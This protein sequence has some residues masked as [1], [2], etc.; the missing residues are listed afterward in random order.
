MVK[1]RD[2]ATRRRVDERKGMKEKS[3][4]RGKEGRRGERRVA[5]ALGRATLPCRRG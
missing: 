2:G 3:D 1:E 5:L 4:A